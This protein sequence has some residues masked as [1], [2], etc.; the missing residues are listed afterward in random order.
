MKTQTKDEKRYSIGKSLSS[1]FVFDRI[2][3]QKLYPIYGHLIEL[4][5]IDDLYRCCDLLNNEDELY[6]K[7]IT[8]YVER[9]DEH[10]YQV[11]SIFFKMVLVIMNEQSELVTYPKKND[12]DFYYFKRKT[13]IESIKLD[14]E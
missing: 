8:N 12:S 3:Q 4:D 10:R 11:F 14:N 2:N 13:F 7:V 5:E 1:L 9:N 6:R